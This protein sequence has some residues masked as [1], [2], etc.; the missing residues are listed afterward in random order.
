MAIPFQNAK[1]VQARFFRRQQSFEITQDHQLL[2]SVKGPFKEESW[3]TPLRFIDPSPTRI[4]RV[5][6]KPLILVAPLALIAL[7][8]LVAAFAALFVGKESDGLFVIA[9]FFGI[10]AGGFSWF[11]F[12]NSVNVL[13][14]TGSN[15]VRLPLWFNNPTRDHFEGFVKALQD[16]IKAAQTIIPDDQILA[17]EIQ[18]LKELFDRGLLDK[19][20][21]ESAKNKLTGNDSNRKVGF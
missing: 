2:V 17:G 10:P 3:D 9:G 16:S 7:P 20:Q 18:K 8:C 14:F 15:G 4:R 11:I 13:T 6:L 12:R 1:L 21:F 19:E 5:D